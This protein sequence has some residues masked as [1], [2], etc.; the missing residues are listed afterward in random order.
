MKRR[1]QLAGLMDAPD[2]SAIQ[3]AC[4]IEISYITLYRCFLGQRSY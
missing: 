1:F 2:R 3:M 4:R